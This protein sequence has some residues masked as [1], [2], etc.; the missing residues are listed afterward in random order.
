MPRVETVFGNCGLQNHILGISPHVGL[1]ICAGH[2]WKLM[3]MGG[4]MCVVGVVVVAV[5]FWGCEYFGVVVVGSDLMTLMMMMVFGCCC[6]CCSCW[7]GRFGNGKL[8]EG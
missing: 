7:C 2:V 3:V 1:D 4:W 6:S 8:D 5:G